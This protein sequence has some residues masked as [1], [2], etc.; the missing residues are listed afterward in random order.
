MVPMFIVS[1]L[2][3]CQEDGRYKVFRNL[4][5]MLLLRTIL[6]NSNHDTFDS[7]GSERQIIKPNKIVSVSVWLS[8]SRIGLSSVRHHI[9]RPW[10]E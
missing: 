6:S 9:Y 7:N 2:Q 3:R 5:R 4:G 10:T 8:G 1:F